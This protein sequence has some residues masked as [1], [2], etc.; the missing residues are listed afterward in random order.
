M[1]IA[2]AILLSY[3]ALS[4]DEMPARQIIVRNASVFDSVIGQMRPNQTIVIQDQKIVTV[5][6]HPDG[7]VADADAVEIDATGKFIIPGLID[8]HCHSVFI[9]DGAGIPA[10]EAL[11]LYLKFGITSIRTM[12]DALEPAKALA[13]CAMTN[14]A[15]YP[16]LFLGSP[17]IDSDPPFHK[18]PVSK[19]IN[20]PADVPAFVQEMADAGVTTMKLYMNAKPEVGRAVIE[21]AHKRGMTVA[22]H[23]VAYDMA[24]AANDGIDTIEHVIPWPDKPIAPGA[25]DGILE[26]MAKHKTFW[27]PTL[28]MM[29]AMLGGEQ[30]G[31]ADDPAVAQMPENIRSLSSDLLM[32]FIP[33]AQ[34]EQL[35][36]AFDTYLKTVGRAHEMDIP[37]LTGTDGA[38]TL[39]GISLHQE[40]ELL[41]QA[42]LTQAAALQ[43]ATINPARAL[44]QEHV[45]GSITPGKQADLIILDANP[46]DDIR[47]TRKINGII[48]QGHPCS[49][50]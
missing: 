46:L 50:S 18:G 44:K 14:P 37:I 29:K 17:F 33:A 30:S 43:A 40:L 36:D 10:A 11:P 42:G 19:G 22:G 2:M 49:M 27:T 31:L 20:D 12:G 16:Q 26:A 35:K 1:N 5:A 48:H 3:A 47:N 32:T 15:K 9:L 25:Y 8:M 45:L 41:V 21:E 7:L 13:E 38:M 39:P 23:M 4:A 6:E 28:V 34:R 24:Q